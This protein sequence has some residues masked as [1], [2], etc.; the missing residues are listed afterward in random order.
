MSEITREREAG[1]SERGNN[2]RVSSLSLTHIHYTYTLAYLL[3]LPRE[4]GA[5]VSVR[6]ILRE[7]G[8][9]RESVREAASVYVCV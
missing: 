6:E 8:T 1:S 5:G 3:P 2:V 9:T 7:R 4:W